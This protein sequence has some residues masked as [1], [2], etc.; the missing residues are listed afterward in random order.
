MARMIPVS[1][2]VAPRDIVITRLPWLD[3]ISCENFA[4]LVY[5]DRFDGRAPAG[6]S[7]RAKQGIVDRFFSCLNDRFVKRGE[8]L[9]VSDFR[10]RE[11]RRIARTTHAGRSRKTYH[12]VARAVSSYRPGS[13]QTH[14]CAGPESPEIAIRQWSIGRDDDHYRPIDF[15]AQGAGELVTAQLPPDWSSHDLQNAAEIALNQHSNSP[16][17]ESRRYP[18]RRRPDS[19]LPLERPRAGSSSDAAFVNGASASGGKTLPD[20]QS[21]HRTRANGDVELVTVIGFADHRIDGAHILH[22]GEPEHRLDECV[23]DFPDAE[24]ASEKDRRF[25]LA[26][27]IYLG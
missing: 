18:A 5:R 10:R 24:C 16:P 25:Q 27:L 26:E 20:V 19:A 4:H 11:P 1:A 9:G 15:F 7:G 8:L 17:A 12:V 6:D 21:G 13:R 23:G 14:Q 3:S 2:A 22:S